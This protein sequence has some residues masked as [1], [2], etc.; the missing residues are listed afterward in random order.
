MSRPAPIYTELKIN[1]QNNDFPS[2]IN[3]LK[4]AVATDPGFIKNFLGEANYKSFRDKIAARK[5]NFN[6]AEFVEM[7]LSQLDLLRFSSPNQ[8]ERNVAD[9]VIISLNNRYEIEKKDCIARKTAQRELNERINNKVHTYFD[10][11][12]YSS[13]DFLNPVRNGFNEQEYE[14][15]AMTKY[16]EFKATIFTKF[17]ELEN[18]NRIPNDEDYISILMTQKHIALIALI[19]DIEEK[20]AILVRGIPNPDS[21]KL[22]LDDISREINAPC[23]ICCVDYEK[24]V[25]LSLL[26]CTHL[27][28]TACIEKWFLKQTNCPTCRK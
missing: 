14:A 5:P 26:K 9:A 27:F 17:V 25:D 15:Y 20:E 21:F 13:D 24:G 3:W 16:A 4:L 6:E 22:R 18:I 7:F 12:D 10:L 19:H 8:T 23:S 28:H 11:L 1:N 2:I